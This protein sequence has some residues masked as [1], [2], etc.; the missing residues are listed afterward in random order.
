MHHRTIV[1]NWHIRI[2]LVYHNYNSE[3]HALSTCSDVVDPVVEHHERELDQHAQRGAFSRRR[4]PR[5]YGVRILEVV[6]G[7]ALHA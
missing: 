3:L 4:Y 2:I 6:A 1:I 7:A 5:E